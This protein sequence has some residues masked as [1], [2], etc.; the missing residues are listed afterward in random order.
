MHMLPSLLAVFFFSY[1]AFVAVFS[2]CLALVRAEGITCMGRCV[3]VVFLLS[4]SFSC[5]VVCPR[6]T[7]VVVPPC[8][9]LSLVLSFAVSF[10]ALLVVTSRQVS[11]FF[12]SPSLARACKCEAMM[13]LVLLSPVVLVAVYTVPHVSIHAVAQRI[14]VLILYTCICVGVC[15]NAWGAGLH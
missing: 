12:S 6:R 8:C 1:G 2:C 7:L 15:R 14:N 10:F 11:R 3:C 9:L 13:F 4:C 5:F